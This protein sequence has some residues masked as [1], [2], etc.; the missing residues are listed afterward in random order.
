MSVKF[1]N[2]FAITK[3]NLDKETNRKQYRRDVITRLDKEASDAIGINT[4]FFDN[5]VLILWENFSKEKY[6]SDVLGYS[7]K[8]ILER[9]CQKVKYAKQDTI[10]FIESP[11]VLGHTMADVLEAI[12]FIWKKTGKIPYFINNNFLDNGYISEKARDIS[13]K[14]LEEINKKV[15]NTKSNFKKR[16]GR[17]A[18]EQSYFSEKQSEII[19]ELN[20]NFNEY[21]EKFF[22]SIS[23]LLSLFNNTEETEERSLYIDLYLSWQLGEK[24]VEDCCKEYGEIERQTWYRYADIFEKSVIYEEIC[25]I[26]WDKLINTKKKGRVPDTFILLGKLRE[27][28]TTDTAISVIM[29][30]KDYCYFGLSDI[31]ARVDVPRCVMV[32]LDRIK[33][34]KHKGIYY[35]KLK[36]LGIEEDYSKYFLTLEETDKLFEEKLA[37]HLE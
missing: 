28:Y 11:D 24:S 21:F 14:Y 10:V 19:S 4:I 34:L 23:N 9:F 7:K 17:D 18:L 1:S 27:I 25:N 37:R 15:D 30:N 29:L 5:N 26:Y 2:F 12:N 31:N 16:L 36:E 22:T 3:A 32:A 35:S 33:I 13:G 6:I 20:K 8:D